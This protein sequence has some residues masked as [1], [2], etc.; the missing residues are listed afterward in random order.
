MKVSVKSVLFR[1]LQSSNANA[2]L[3]NNPGE[4]DLRIGRSDD[5]MAFASDLPEESPTNLG[6]WTKTLAIEPLDGDATVPAKTIRLRYMGPSARRHNDL[7]FAGQTADTYPLWRPDRNYAGGVTAS[8]IVGDVVLVVRDT[9]DRLHARYVR[10]SELGS[11]PAALAER[12][13]QNELG[14][15]EVTGAT[16]ELSPA[17][18]E[19]LHAL[20]THM[21]VLVYGPPGTGKTHL[22]AEV[23][24][25][26][27]SGGLTLDTGAERDALADSSL[28]ARSAWTTFHQSY[29]YEDFLVGLRPKPIDKGGFVLEAHPGVLL[30]LAE[31]ARQSPQH[32]S[33]LVIDEINRGNVSRIFGEFI[34][35][36]EPEKR[37]GKDGQATDTTLEVRLPFVD[38]QSQVSVDFGDGN[39]PASVQVP[40]TMPHNVYTLATMNSVDKSVAPLD[41]ALRRRF[42][43]IDL[44]PRLDRFRDHLGLDPR[45]ITQSDIPTPLATAADAK[46]LGI[47]L[48]EHLNRG[49]TKFLGPDFQF[50][51]WFLKGLS[52]ATT[53]EDAEQQIAELWRNSLMPQLEDYFV[54]RAD[55]LSALLGKPE[56]SSKKAAALAI[57]KPTDEEARLGAS[58]AIRAEPS[59]SDDD[60]IEFLATMVRKYLPPSTPSPSVSDAAETPESQE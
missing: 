32:A 4:H 24:R 45:E 17:A 55:Q 28:K 54:G 56:A 25:Q 50:G 13:T 1:K 59:A 44:N 20:K 18:A 11:L 43:V 7:Y 21:N 9:D 8:E 53:L 42:F 39:V 31:W 12:I 3:H 2:L 5:I 47:A 10:K 19:I 23:R 41:A 27:G 33:L 60:V 48:I 26:F 22:V 46:W 57:T 36:M 49:V 30:E 38:A 34:T 15:Y 14:V 16:K 35:L 40:F 29:S 58:L 6:G 37:C 52:S 51:E